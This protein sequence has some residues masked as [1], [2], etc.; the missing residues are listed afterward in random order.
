M[1]RLYRRFV[2]RLGITLLLFMHLA[3]AAH[4]CGR[5]HGFDDVPGPPA[6]AHHAHPAA[7]EDGNSAHQEQVIDG[8]GAVPSKLC[9]Q[10]CQQGSQVTDSG[11]AAAL[12]PVV[13]P[14]LAVVAV[15]GNSAGIVFFRQRELLARQTAPPASIRFCVLRS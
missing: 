6:D 13:L 5:L 10:H 4:A 12:S 3:V 2:A 15:D 7:V 9:M 8:H 11:A 14:L 1:N